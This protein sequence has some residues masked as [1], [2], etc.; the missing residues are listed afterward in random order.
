MGEHGL[1]PRII[2]RFEGGFLDGLYIT[3]TVFWAIIVSVF[4]VLFA[5]ISTRK[6]K[7]IPR[8]AQAY[9]E[10]I[11]EYV[12]KFT[13]DSMGKDKLMFAPFIGTLFLFLL[14]GNALGL[15]GFR[16][17]TADMNATFALGFLVFLMI[18]YNAIRSRGIIGY[19]KHFAEPY[20]FMIPIK[21]MEEITFPVSLSFRIFGNILAGVIIMELVLEA[22]K[23]LSTEVIKLPIPI[24]QAV[25]PLPLNGFFD[26]FEPI[27]QAFVFTMLTMTFIAKAMAAHSEH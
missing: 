4:L 1:G 19:L 24:L 2:L 15:I 26:I 23:H 25:L 13:R 14:F 17:V 5:V 8:G 11:V 7:K 9:A 18:Q 21:I 3:E 6:L 27:L 12:Y 10:L 20:P 22:L 16:P